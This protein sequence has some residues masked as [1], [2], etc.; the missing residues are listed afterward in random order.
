M[1][2]VGSDERRGI[3]QATAGG[4]VESTKE[5]VVVKVCLFCRS[6]ISKVTVAQE[7]SVPMNCDD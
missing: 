2:D 7:S 5:Q 1:A 6:E 4:D 3:P